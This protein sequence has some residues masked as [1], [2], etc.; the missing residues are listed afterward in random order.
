MPPTAP[1]KFKMAARKKFR[2]W[3][4]IH[5]Q[6]FLARAN[7]ARAVSVE[8]KRAPRLP[9]RW[10]IRTVWAAHRAIY[11]VTGGRLGLKSAT[12]DRFGTLRLRTI[13]RRT[14]EERKVIV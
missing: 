2:Q 11:A 8:P 4:L 3:T 1:W 14:G 5:R 6:R 10:F 13:G 9:P 7:V 12:P